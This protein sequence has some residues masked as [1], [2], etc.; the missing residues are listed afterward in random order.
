MKNKSA[1]GSTVEDDVDVWCYA[2]LKLHARNDDDDD[3]YNRLPSDRHQLSN[4]DWR[5]RGKGRLS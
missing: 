5:I 4:E 1:R 3:C 2:I